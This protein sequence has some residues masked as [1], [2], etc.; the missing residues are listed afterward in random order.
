MIDVDH[1]K[2]VNDTHGHPTGDQ[3]LMALGRT[4]GCDC[5]SPTSSGAM[6]ARSSPSS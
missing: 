1:F 4:L 2:A 6:A 5:A 3:V